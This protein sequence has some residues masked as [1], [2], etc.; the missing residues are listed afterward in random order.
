[1]SRGTTI[2]TIR[3]DDDA[4]TAAMDA[5]AAQGTSVSEVVR[6]LLADWVADD[7]DETPRNDA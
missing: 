5:A 6:A 1:M 4:W 2:R 3:V 7:H